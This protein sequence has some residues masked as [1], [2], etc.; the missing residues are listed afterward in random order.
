MVRPSPARR[1]TIVMYGATRN[2]LLCK[3]RVLKNTATTCSKR[4]SILALFA[5]FPSCF[6]IHT[7]TCTLPL[8][9]ILIFEFQDE[10]INM[11]SLNDQHDSSTSAQ[12]QER[13]D[14]KEDG[15]ENQGGRLVDIS[16]TSNHVTVQA[17]S[18]TIR[19]QWPCHQPAT[20]C[21]L[22][23]QLLTSTAQ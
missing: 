3:V 13:G 8:V 5:I 4:T 9:L 7:C 17:T 22:I 2:V 6:L 21:S 15:R 16:C 12:E 1:L 19:I 14:F 20:G 10:D 18:W 23:C 11:A